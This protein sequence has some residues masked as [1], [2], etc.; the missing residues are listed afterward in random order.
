MMQTLDSSLLY[1]RADGT[2]GFVHD[3]MRD[4]FL[5]LYFVSK[6]K[7]PRAQLSNSAVTLFFSSKVR[8]ATQVISQLRYR[9]K[10]TKALYI[11]TGS[12]NYQDYNEGI[13]LG[14]RCLAEATHVQPRQRA[15]LINDAL[16]KVEFKPRSSWRRITSLVDALV[17]LNDSF[18]NRSL[19]DIVD[20]SDKFVY[21]D[22]DEYVLG[23]LEGS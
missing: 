1:K 18:V 9:V 8:D 22:R 16:R 11:F 7:L 14:L 4:Y 13:E 19:R 20:R 2:Q 17:E 15:R 21:S 6:G 3:S 5:A 23:R 10:V 12:R